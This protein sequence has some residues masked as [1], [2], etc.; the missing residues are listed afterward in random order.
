M[1]FSPN[2][3]KLWLTIRQS[4]KIIIKL[5]IIDQL[6]KWWFINYLPGK[7]NLVI[8]VT[9]FFDIVYSWNFGISFGIMRQYHQYSNILFMILNSV[10]VAYLW[11]QMARGKS[12]T[13]FVA[14]SFVIGG[15]IGNLMDR[16][17][18]GAVFDFLYFHYEEYGFPIFNLADSFI[19]IGVLLLVQ[20]YYK[21]KKIVE[22]ARIAEY[23]KEK[24][25]A[26]AE[27]IIKKNQGE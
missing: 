23:D 9:S 12:I 13:G 3:H 22:E 24:I 18:Q 6:T 7:K 26:E 25:A 8:T 1:A 2:L 10:I 27:S 14:Y 19:S 4:S 16:F 21:D 11:C 15:A 17:I 20:E 5:I